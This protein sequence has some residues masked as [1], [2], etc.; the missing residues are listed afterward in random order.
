[1]ASSETTKVS[2]R[3]AFLQVPFKRV[4]NIERVQ[5]D[6]RLWQPH[7]LAYAPNGPGQLYWDIEVVLGSEGEIERVLMI[8]KPRAPF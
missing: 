2:P 3:D 4:W 6:N 7:R 5:T 8:Y 1:M